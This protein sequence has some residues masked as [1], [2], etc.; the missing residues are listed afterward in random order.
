MF[1]AAV[2]PSCGGKEEHRQDAEYQTDISGNGLHPAK[3]C[4]ERNAV[5]V[6][7]PVVVFPIIVGK[8]F[9]VAKPSEPGAFSVSNMIFWMAIGNVTI[10]GIG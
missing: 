1:L 2:P 3:Y 7:G 6:H 5:V 4:T 10:Y 9:R 8:L